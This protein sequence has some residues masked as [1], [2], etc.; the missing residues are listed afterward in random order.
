MKYKIQKIIEVGSQLSITVDHDYGTDVFGLS[1][2]SKKLDP[3]TDKPKFLSQI[4]R[5]LEKKYGDKSRKEKEVFKEFVG[6]NLENKNINVP[7]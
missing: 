5:L 3:R 4:D 7:K 6:K 2:A 1:L